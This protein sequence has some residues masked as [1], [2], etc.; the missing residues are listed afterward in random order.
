MLRG[1]PYTQP[2]F[3]SEALQRDYTQKAGHVLENS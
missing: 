3:V 1:Q 2:L